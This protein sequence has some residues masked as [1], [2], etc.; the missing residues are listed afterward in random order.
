MTDECIST[1]E[2]ITSATLKMN[3]TPQPNEVFDGMNDDDT[4]GS[5]GIGNRNSFDR[6]DALGMG[7]EENTNSA[8]YPS[9]GNTV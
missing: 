9:N 8:T 5:H 1:C 3:N 4:V 6:P 7:C 2:Y